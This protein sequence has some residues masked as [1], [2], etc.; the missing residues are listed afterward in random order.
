MRLNKGLIAVIA[1]SFI[2]VNAGL[3]FG[4]EQT[5]AAPAQETEEPELQF[6]WGEVV[7][8]DLANKTILVKNLDYETDQE[9]E[10]PI[11]VDEKTVFENFKSIE[12]LK[13]NDTV[14]VDYIITP[15]G[16]NIARNISLDSVEEDI[17]IPEESP[18]PASATETK[19]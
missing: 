10:T 1:V 15:D 6:L 16:K 13:Q 11:L 5:K 4:Q 9:R 3:S 18:K 2:L 7:N 12:G 19:P 8:L 14:S 17:P